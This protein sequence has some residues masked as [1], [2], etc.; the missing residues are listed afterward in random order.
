MSFYRKRKRGKDESAA[1]WGENH[2]KE[3][4]DFLTYSWFSQVLFYFILFSRGKRE[5]R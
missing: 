5:T 1:N 3:G 2:G 4:S